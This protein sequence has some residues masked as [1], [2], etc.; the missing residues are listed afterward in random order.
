MKCHVTMSLSRSWFTQVAAILHK[1]DLPYASH[2]AAYETALE[3]QDQSSSWCLLERTDEII[4][5]VPAPT[6]DGDTAWHMK[7]GRIEPDRYSKGDDQ[8][9]TYQHLHPWDTHDN[10]EEKLRIPLQAMQ[11]VR[12]YQTPLPHQC[13]SLTDTS[14]GYWAEWEV[15]ISI[16]WLTDEEKLQLILDVRHHSLTMTL[17]DSKLDRI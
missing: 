10:V 14:S 15:L 2:G 12:Q 8:G 11:L 4:N 9:K 5:P 16:N 7:T 6:T 3:R 1:Y 13:R 17:D